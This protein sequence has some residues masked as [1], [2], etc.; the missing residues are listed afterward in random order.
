[1]RGISPFDLYPRLPHE[2]LPEETKVGNI[3][4]L[5]LPF[6]FQGSSIRIPGKRVSRIQ[7][8]IKQTIVY[9]HTQMRVSVRRERGDREEN[10]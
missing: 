4:G 7:A 2:Y 5:D 8:V 3:V 10:Y 9:N 6:Q 1:M